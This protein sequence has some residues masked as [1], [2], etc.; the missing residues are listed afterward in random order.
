MRTTLSLDPEVLNAARQIAVAR[1]TSIG[2]V[3]SELARQGLESKATLKVR[4]GFPV[5][6]VSKGGR[7]LTLEDIHIHEDDI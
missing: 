3:I 1:S 7:L 5:F 6:P 2:V 4:N